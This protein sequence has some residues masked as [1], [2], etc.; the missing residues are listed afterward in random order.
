MALRLRGQETT[1]TVSVDGQV[2][3]GSFTLVGDLKLNDVADKAQSDFLGESTSRW[4]YQHHGWTFSFTIQEQDNAAFN[5]VV[6]PFVAADAAGNPF[7]NV[8]LIVTKRYRDPATPAETIK[9]SGGLVL[10]WDDHG[11][12]G[13]KEYVKST[14]SGFCTDAVSY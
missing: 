13:R 5:S 11:F 10:T 14:F 7:P 9:L 8:V 12:A 2:L 3:G 1:L 6:A 4:D